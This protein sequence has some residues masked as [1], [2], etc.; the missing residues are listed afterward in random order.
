MTQPVFIVSSGRS[1]TAMME[2]L[3][4]ANPNIEMHHEYMVHLVQPIACRFAMGL[5]SE[6][7]VLKIV[8]QTYG[9]ALHYAR[10]PLWGDSSNKL[11]WIVPV[12]ARTFPTA[13]FV[14]LARDG[15]KVASSYF[16]KL[17]NECYDDEAVRVLRA[18]AAR[19][20]QVPPPPPEKRYWW[21][22]PCADDPHAAA[23]WNYDQFQRIVWHWRAINAKILDGLTHVPPANR[24][25]VRLE[26]MTESADE[27]ARFL[28]FIGLKPS[29]EDFAALQRPHNVNRPEDKLL[30]K[31]QTAE[32][33]A[34][35]GDMM[36]ALGYAG[37]PEYTVSYRPRAMVNQSLTI[38]S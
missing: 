3:L 21:P 28:E 13:K 36:T 17:A 24:L 18:H 7:D 14:H 38:A 25:F 4:G 33:W 32:F 9:A 22:L 5:C 16:H 30:T 10:K 31:D 35:A 8:E 2:R 37:R 15:R 34:I 12:L 20:D 19:P 1:G 29:P 23:F 26:D 27:A 6:T 11:S